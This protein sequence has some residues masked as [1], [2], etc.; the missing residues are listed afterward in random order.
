M[1]RIQQEI[2]SIKE[3][4]QFLSPITVYLEGGNYKL[5]EPLILNPGDS[6]SP[7]KIIT[8]K[9]LSGEK[10]VFNGGRSLSGWVKGKKGLWAAQNPGGKKW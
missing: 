8:F 3:N 6:G 9:A 4:G 7:E 10:P 1:H 2:R 5:T